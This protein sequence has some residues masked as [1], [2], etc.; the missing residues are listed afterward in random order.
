MPSARP[1]PTDVAAMLDDG[2][3]ASVEQM[4]ALVVELLGEMQKDV[5][6]RHNRVRDQFYDD[7]DPLLEIRA[8]SRASAWLEPRLARFDVHDVVEHELEERNRC[9]LTA[10][11]MVG[12]QARMVV[13]EGKGQ[14]HRDL[15][16]AA[17]AQLADRYGDHPHADEQ[18]IFLVIWYGPDV[19][20]AGRKQHDF[21]TA[22]DL[23]AAIV[24]AL[25]N[26]LRRRVDVFVLDVS[27]T[28]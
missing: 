11:R 5:R 17:S 18:G 6:S 23:R 4:R 7:G 9:D 27:D 8:M 10:T 24:D 2:L 3:P 12:G 16:T 28:A 14:W 19:A 15:F 20:V 21:K 25:P 13:I 1:G 22:E 26:D